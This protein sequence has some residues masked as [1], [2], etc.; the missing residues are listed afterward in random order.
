MR[1]VMAPLAVVAATVMALPGAGEAG[2]MRQ[3]DAIPMI[4]RIDREIGSASGHKS[5]FVVSLGRDVIVRLFKETHARTTWTVRVGFD[6]QPGSIRYLRINKRYFQTDQPSF[7]GAE[8]EEIVAFLK[9][10]GEFAFEW[11]QRPND[12]KRPGLFGTGNFAAKLAECER[13]ITG[14]H[15]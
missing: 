7:R 14:T 5:C 10:P 12:A 1:R 9:L 15:V 2:L 11:A 4:W 3:I 13:W 6:N 8:A